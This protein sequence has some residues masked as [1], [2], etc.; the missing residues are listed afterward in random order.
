[1]GGKSLPWYMLGLSNASDM[2]D[3]SG[4][5]WMV[6]ILFVYGFKS[7]WLPWLWPSFNQIFLMVFLS[8][9]LRRS[10]A[11]TGA[12]WI[13]TRFGHGRG[14]AQSHAVV[15]AFALI[16]CLGFLAYGFIGL[17]KFIEIFLPWETVAPYLPF[18]LEA[19]WVPHF[20]GIL[21]TLFAVFYSVL[22]G[23]S[24]I[25]WGDVIMYSMMTLASLCVGGI[26][27]YHLQ[28][29]TLNVPESWFS[30]GFGWTLDMGW[31][32]ILPELGQKAA[33]DG[34]T[35]FGAF[36]MMMVFK[37]VLASLAGPA[38][39]YD[40]QKILSTR[41]PQ[42]ASKM[43]GFVSVVLMPVRYTM[44]TGFAVL[45][46]LYYK[47]LNL[48][49]VDASG[50]S[51][52]DFERILPAAINNFIPAGLMGLVLAGLIAAFM[53]TFAGTLNAAQSY[54]VNDIYLKHL[55]PKAS[56]G[57][58]LAMNYGSGLV[59]M[60][61][62]IVLGLWAGS[63]E[64]ILQWIVGGLYAGYVA[65]NVL[66][67]YWWRF[68]APGYFW[69][70]A[71]GIG[72]ALALPSLMTAFPGFFTQKLPIFYFP[73]LLVVSM[74]GCLTGTLLAP[75]TEMETL[76]SFYRK[77]RPWGF[78]QPVHAAVVAETPDFQGNKNFSRDMLNVFTGIVAQMAMTLL[79]MYFILGK[80]QNTSLML[81]M[82]AGCAWMLKRNWW[83]PLHASAADAEG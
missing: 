19:R 39:N 47:Q 18:D 22:G 23:M 30:P 5:M 73:L 55:R 72:M 8:M 74:A 61:V 40:M 49:A 35:L 2:F 58:V 36:F 51:Y 75:P 62:S 21:F 69:G 66:K 82:I 52:L 28:G 50:R 60:A 37:G 56:H 20:Y 25:V 63:V 79:P 68:N 7:I 1:M 48:H 64:A 43:S 3:I 11:A 29:Q 78:W 57:S 71:A 9:W 17:G 44:I 77:V 10:H 76:K 38:P 83:D 41:S 59:V 32:P 53:G 14:V 6:S 45:A 65:A 70:M 27:M 80:W 15:V 24:G 42:E 46:L 34:Y 67:W 4:T 12:A 26:A 13:H 16:G 81:V 54:I 31:A 33:E